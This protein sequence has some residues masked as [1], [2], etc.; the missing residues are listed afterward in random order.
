MSN[1]RKLDPR[2]EY[3]ESVVKLLEGLLEKAKAG[4]VSSVFVVYDVDGERS[5]GTAMSR[6]Y[7]RLEALGNLEVLKIELYRSMEE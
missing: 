5:F 4:E 6:P 2:K 1:I 3:Q 7:N